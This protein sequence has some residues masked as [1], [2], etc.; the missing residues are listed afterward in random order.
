MDPQQA[1][2]D[3]LTA[4]KDKRWDDAKELA[5]ALHAWLVKGGFPP[6]TLGHV[7]LG[8]EWHRTV[9]T[10][11]CLAASSK[12]DDIRKSRQRRSSNAPSKGDD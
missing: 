7:S 9:A 5:D 12:V 11:V 3:L 1:L 10:F 6:T 8:K 2:A 4:L